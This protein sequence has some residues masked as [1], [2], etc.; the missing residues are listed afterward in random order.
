VK[1]RAGVGWFAANLGDDLSS[2]G[3][4]FDAAV[5]RGAAE[6]FEGVG[7]GAPVLAHDDADGLVDEESGDAD[8]SPLA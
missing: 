2:E 7:G 5:V 1:R 8:G 4:E 6:D 3:A